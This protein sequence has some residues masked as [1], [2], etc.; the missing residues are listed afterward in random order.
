MNRT[1]QRKLAIKLF[2]HLD[3]KLPDIIADET[4]CFSTILEHLSKYR[5]EVIEIIKDIEIPSQWAY[6]WAIWVGD[7]DIMRDRVTESLWA[8]KWARYIGDKDVMIDRVVESQ[9]A[10]HWA[11]RISDE[12]VMIARVMDEF[13][14]NEW[15][16]NIGEINPK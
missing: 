1:E 3:P 2:G 9:W 6:K 16:E 7:H 5:K 15:K 14:I 8:Y 12:D 10:Y 4:N 13:W 11:L